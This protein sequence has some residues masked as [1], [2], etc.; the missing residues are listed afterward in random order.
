MMATVLLVALV[1]QPAS[2]ADTAAG[3]PCKMIIDSV[4]R[5]AQRV[6]VRRGEN[7]VFAGHGVVD[8]LEGTRRTLASARL[9]LFAGHKRFNTRGPTNQVHLPA[10]AK[11]PHTQ[12]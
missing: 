10:N 1:Q 9:A 3:R 11:T 5:Q 12:T 4:G 6:E 2:P 8:H 7:N